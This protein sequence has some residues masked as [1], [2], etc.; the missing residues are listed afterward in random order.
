MRSRSLLC[1]G[2]L[3]QQH[4]AYLNDCCAWFTS[5][6]GGGDWAVVSLLCPSGQQLCGGKDIVEEGSGL[7]RACPNPPHVLASF[8]AQGLNCYNCTMIPFGN[9]CSSTATCPYPDGVCTIQVAEVVVSKFPV[10]C[11]YMGGGGLEEKVWV[12]VLEHGS[13][14]SR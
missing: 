10:A 3:R 5:P 14:P 6:F 7:G 1:G 8:S 9:T 2:S 11:I 13:P 4:R 12:Q